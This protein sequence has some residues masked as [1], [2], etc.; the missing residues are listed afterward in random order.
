MRDRNAAGLLASDMLRR[1]QANGAGGDPYST[2][3]SADLH[4]LVGDYAKSLREQGR[5]AAHF[6][7]TRIRLWAAS[8]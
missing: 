1:A 7:K 2:T 6:E 8:T 5:K 4:E 3:R